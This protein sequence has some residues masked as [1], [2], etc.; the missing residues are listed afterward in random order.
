MVARVSLDNR[1]LAARHGA[2][3]S[4]EHVV[5]GTEF[6]GEIKVAEDA[7][8]LLPLLLLAIAELRLRGLGRG[9]LVDARIEDGG[10]LDPL[11][12]D[13]WR[14]LLRALR[15]WLWEGWLGHAAHGG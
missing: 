1:T 14:P 2:L 13:E 15:S 7:R 3:Y 4:V 8:G 12:G 6:S 5:P 10:A 11:V 9:A